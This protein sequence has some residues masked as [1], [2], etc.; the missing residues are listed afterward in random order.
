LHAANFAKRQRRGRVAVEGAKR[1]WP[2]F[3]ARACPWPVGMVLFGR[4]PWAIGQQGCWDEVV[5]RKE[6]KVGLIHIAYRPQQSMLIRLWRYGGG[7]SYPIFEGEAHTIPD[8]R[9][10]GNNMYALG[11]YLSHLLWA[12]E[13]CQWKLSEQPEDS[14][15]VSSMFITL[16]CRDIRNKAMMSSHSV[17]SLFS[18]PSFCI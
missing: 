2:V 10:P 15:S 14:C 16:F 6:W 17:T 3:L 11:F 5:E 12:V 4:G 13:G 1:S 7:V 9:T 8:S 18:L